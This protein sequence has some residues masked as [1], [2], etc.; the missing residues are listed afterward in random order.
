[1]KQLYKI[2][3]WLL[4][5]VAAPVA[6]F[7]QSDTAIVKRDTVIVTNTVIVG[8][9]D[10][11]QWKNETY[12]E[13]N[14]YVATSIVSGSTFIGDTTF[15]DT[16][17]VDTLHLT[18]HN[19]L[20]LSDSV[21]VCESYFWHDSL[22]MQSGTHFYEHTDA[23]GCMQVD[24]LHLTILNGTHNVIDAAA[25][26]SY[27]WHGMTYTE[28]GMYTY[29]YTNASGCASVDTL[30]LTV[31]Y[32]THNVEIVIACE[33]YEWHNTTYTESGTYTYS[34]TNAAGCASV[35]TLKLTVYYGT[36]NVDTVTTCENYVW[37]G[38]TYRESGTYTY[39]YNSAAGCASVDTLKLT[40][41]YGTHNVET[42]T[43]CESY[44]W[45]GTTYTE[46]GT[47]TYSYTNASG[48]ASVDTLQLT[49][50]QPYNTPL[51][52][53]ICQGDTYDFFGQPLATQGVYT[54]TLE[55]V[56]GCD[57]IITLTLTVLPLPTPFITGNN[58]ICSYDTTTLIAGG[59]MEY[60][61]S[62]GE[63]NNQIQVSD[64]GTYY[65]TVTDAN[66]CSNVTSI[67]VSLAPTDTSLSDAIVTKSH[68][69]VPYM[70]IYPKANLLYQWYENGVAIQDETRQ[71][72]APNGGLQKHICYKVLA[73]PL[74]TD[75]C[76]V[77]T[78][79]WELTDTS[80]AKIHILPNPND[81]Q[82]R[83]LLPEGTVSV[84]VL[85][86]NGQTVMTRKVNGVLV[87]DMTT[88]LTNGLYFVKT[89][90]Q[91]GSF[92]T[93]KLVINR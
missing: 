91:D 1:M 7:G 23:N 78:Q 68:D 77:L 66:R 24:T 8:T 27:T 61:W 35:D 44:T 62:T 43:A 72:Y 60:E 64:I 33:N 59:G 13:S 31:H 39:S 89:F 90:R 17:F 28:S 42:M 14:V 88:N 22:Y 9:C 63:T 12:T 65:V 19:P 56:N 53:S 26:E 76:G 82:F 86:A 54:K 71:Y 80:T 41:N 58:E 15:V 34:Y 18:I 51:S 20:H 46:S 48:C 16:I 3:I 25:C 93:E 10:S 74:D 84:Q 30:K 11:Y 29:P 49:I 75:K 50:Y 21:T 69:G 4:I 73:R 92:N 40:V 45:H 70:L 5:V 2:A 87:V 79:C 83:L 85:N 38:T 6:G 57:S 47:Y 32:V 36:H 55:T 67:V 52:A 81:G 37:H